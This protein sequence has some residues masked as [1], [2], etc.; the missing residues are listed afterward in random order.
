MGTDRIRIP[1]YM[2]ESGKC[3]VGYRV[4]QFFKPAIDIPHVILTANNNAEV[5]AYTIAKMIDSVNHTTLKQIARDG[6]MSVVRAE[7]EKVREGNPT[8]KE[9]RKLS[10][11]D[12][13]I[14][15]AA[16]YNPKEKEKKK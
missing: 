14:L 3:Y 5:K 2:V 1:Y 8:P 6:L 7:I 13:N 16:A 12:R 9:E 15:K 11:F 10:E 4:N